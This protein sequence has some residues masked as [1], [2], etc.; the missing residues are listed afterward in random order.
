[1]FLTNTPLPHK[2]Q[3]VSD[4]LTANYS[5]RQQ[6]TKNR[7]GAILFY[8]V[9]LK[10]NLRA[11]SE[12]APKKQEQMKQPVGEPT[13]NPQRKSTGLLKETMSN[14]PSKKHHDLAPIYASFPLYDPILAKSKQTSRPRKGVIWKAVNPKKFSPRSTQAQG[15]PKEVSAIAKGAQAR[16]PHSHPAHHHTTHPARRSV[17]SSQCPCSR[18]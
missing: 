3:H 15:G 2:T 8:S 1:M 12:K 13:Q 17:P 14:T 9:F 7:A 5:T 6:V 10:L 18:R 11:S 4:Y 16:L